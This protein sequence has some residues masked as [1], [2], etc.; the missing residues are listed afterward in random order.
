MGQK[1]E[2]HANQAL[3]GYNTATDEGGYLALNPLYMRWAV[4]WG[5]LGSVQGSRAREL[6]RPWE[7]PGRNLAGTRHWGRARA[8]AGRTAPQGGTPA[9]P[10]ARRYT[11]D[12]EGFFAGQTGYGYQ[13]IARFIQA[14]KDVNSGAKSLADV[15]AHSEL[16]VLDTT[17]N[18]GAWALVMITAAAAGPAELPALLRLHSPLPAS[19]ARA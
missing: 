2:L 4:L 16:A 10:A 13:S 19:P 11:P 6:A 17:A 3:R 8:P 7:R 14:A 9:P 15:S 1:G 18:V 5:A 12:A